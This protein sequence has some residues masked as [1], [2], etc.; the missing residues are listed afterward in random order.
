V[1]EENV[2]VAI[3]GTGFG[4]RVQVPGFRKLTGVEV[5]GVMSS[6]RRE[7]AEKIAAE[8][9]IPTVCDSYAEILALPGLDAVSIVTPPYQHA[10]MVLQAFEAG[11]HVLC[12]K[13]MALNVTEARR[14]LEKARETGRVGMIDHEFRY[15]PARAYAK[16]LIDGGYIGKL[17]QANIS[18]V[19]GSAADAQQR[20]WGWLFDRDAGGG[21]LG[22]LGS[23]YIDALRVWFGDITAVTAQ[24]DTFV[25]ERSLPGTENHRPVTADDSF[26]L[27]CRF[28]KGGRASINVSV[29]SRFGAGE[30]IELY[31][32]AGTLVI[33]QKGELLGGKVGDDELHPVRIPA[34]YMDGVA[35]DDPRLRPF[36]TLAKDFVNA[37][38]E[39]RANNAVPVVTPNFYDGY[40]VQQVI[41]AAR[42]AAE[43]N[44]WV[45]LPPF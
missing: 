36:V 32:T 5:V 13:P 29:V 22:A 10:P 41:D 16:E 25:K 26:M 30:R 6:G 15:V 11:K 19:T 31:G 2:K 9:G 39:V 17:L 37:I 21:F 4:G 43:N 38:R 40:K 34:R 33:N 27:M 1:A 35:A 45:S 7:N 18:M 8:F 14:M 42:Q 20:A 24:I 3:V 44:T 12:E 23:H 28:A